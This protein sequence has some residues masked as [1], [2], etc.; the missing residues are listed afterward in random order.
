MRWIL[1]ALVRKGTCEET[2]FRQE[3][4]LADA[5]ESFRAHFFQRSIASTIEFFNRLDNQV[6]YQ[7]KSVLDVGCGLGATSIYLALQ[8]AKKVVGID[9]YPEWKNLPWSKLSTYKNLQDVVVFKY[10][11]ELANDEKFDIV[12]SKDSFEHFSNPEE[13][14]DFMVQHLKPDGLMVI[15]FAPLWKSPYGAHA[16]FL[17]S[18][19]WIHLLFP[20]E[21]LMHEFRR[22][23]KDDRIVSFKDI[24]DGLN[25]MTY[26]RFIDIIQRHGLKFEFLK[27]N[28]SS[29]PKQMIILGIFNVI[30]HIPMLR[31]YF[32]VNVYS[33][34]HR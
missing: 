15:G 21:L 24:A 33:I 18:F 11:E 5:S 26:Q 23:L 7:D 31:E 14:T 13:M 30:R 27:T 28:V 29:N 4:N 16:R 1:R 19:P 22:F 12:L 2:E 3:W 8:G 10:A 32:T 17:T 9:I 34:A 6:N 20:E 25:K